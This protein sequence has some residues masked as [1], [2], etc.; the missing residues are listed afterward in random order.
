MKRLR[1]GHELAVIGGG[2]AG[3][4][5]AGHAA[6]L[7]LSVT[8]FHED[9]L[10][11]G[12]VV[13]VGRLDGYPAVGEVSGA[14]LA[15]ALVEGNRELGVSIHAEPVEGLS[16]DGA[17]KSVATAAGEHRV[18][19]VIVATGARL[20]SLGVP[21]EAEFTGKGV[22]QCAFCDAG[23]YRGRDVVVVGGGD[24]A[25]QEALHLAEFCRSITLVTRGRGLRARRSYV[26][27]AAG[28]ERFSFRWNTVVEQVIGGDGVEAVRLRDLAAGS[29]EELAAA[30]VFVFVGLAPNGDFLPA[31]IARDDTGHIVT[32]A[33]L[34][35]S[36]EGVY[37]AGAVRSGYNGQL[38]GAVGEAATAA[39]AAAAAN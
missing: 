35:T 30:G 38:A 9:D 25:L 2:I 12:L 29:T 1:K 21:G 15:A 36:A 28:D 32:D 19:Q 24:A 27:Q 17:A 22:S 16:L 33:A 4:T 37:A 18:K 10:Y 14:A 34:R 39:I 8:L 5:A 13:N 11:G 3:L 7:G 6:R 23:L 31:E 20:K 26:A